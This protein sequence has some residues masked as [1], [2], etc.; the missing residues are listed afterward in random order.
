MNILMCLGLVVLAQG[1]SY[2]ADLPAGAI[3]RFRPS[4]R[5]GH[6]LAATAIAYS[7]ESKRVYTAGIDNALITWDLKTG[8]VL[9]AWPIGPGTVSDILL[10]F[11]GKLLAIPVWKSEV[12]RGRIPIRKG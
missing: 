11:D 7:P 10:T 6:S 12:E 2:S 8:K 5:S 4:P 3:S 1:R 9:H